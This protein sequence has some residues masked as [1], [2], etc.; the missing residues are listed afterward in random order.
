[1][2]LELSRSFTGALVICCSSWWASA[3]GADR[4]LSSGDPGATA[5]DV[6]DSS[7]T[8]DGNDST[9]GDSTLETARTRVST[10]YDRLLGIAVERATFMCGCEATDEASVSQCVRQSVTI[11]A[12]PIVQCT[13]DVLASDERSL[14]P[15]QCELSNYEAY[16]SCIQES[17]CDDF[18]NIV[19]CDVERLQRAEACDPLPWDLWAANKE[20]C[21]GVPQPEAFECDDGQRINS[22][23]VCDHEADCA[24]ASDE[25]GCAF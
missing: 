21:E 1:M 3:C 13:K 19:S 8:D 9:G 16:L 5:D 15:L 2:R 4:P 20:Q 6:D 14:E 18:D 17:T 24:D 11:P 22:Q 7:A 25:V 23:W 10:M 12:P